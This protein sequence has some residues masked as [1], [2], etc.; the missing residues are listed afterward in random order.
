MTKA[1]SRYAPLM[2]EAISEFV[3]RLP[4]VR[5]LTDDEI[6]AAME[7][8]P[9]VI[10]WGDPR[11]RLRDEEFFVAAGK[12]AARHAGITRSLPREDYVW[13]E[14][15][16]VRYTEL[17]MWQSRMGVQNPTIRQVL[18][19]RRAT[20][21]RVQRAVAEFAPEYQ[22]DE[23]VVYQLA[24]HVWHRGLIRPVVQL[25]YATAQRPERFGSSYNQDPAM[26]EQLVRGAHPRC[27]DKTGALRPWA[28]AWAI[29]QIR[30][31][32]D[33]VTGGNY[34]AISMARP[35]DRA[36]LIAAIRAWK[37]CP[38]LPKKIAVRVGKMPV[39]R[40]LAA[41]VA[42]RQARMSTD[43]RQAAT[44]A[45]WPIFWTVQEE[46]AFVL[47]QAV[48]AAAC[49]KLK[50]RLDEARDLVG[51]LRNSG[52]ASRTRMV[53]EI[54]REATAQATAQEA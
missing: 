23:R 28:I 39:W 18:Q 45:F 44:A 47:N 9:T 54:F 30:G 21:A 36:D 17:R 42:W 26:L 2:N 33:D 51:S 8:P 31:Q 34:R 14:R 50:L 40:R 43:T 10:P 16:R 3:C 4:R 48:V 35:G 38:T 37:R 24:C 29:A 7:A 22:F 53:R 6:R 13:I 12:A 52:F 32:A 11:L 20:C 46:R 15:L 25:W 27:F 49:I 5:A 19:F 41:V 1:A